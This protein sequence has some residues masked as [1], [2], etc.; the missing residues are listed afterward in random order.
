MVHYRVYQLSDPNSSCSTNMATNLFGGRF[1]LAT[2]E[3]YLV[4]SNENE[5]R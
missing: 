4:T 5:A 2:N 3:V 1:G